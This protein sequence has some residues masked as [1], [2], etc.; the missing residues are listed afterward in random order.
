MADDTTVAELDALVKI[1]GALKIITSEV[2]A[3][4]PKN[5]DLT[6]PSSFVCHDV[7]EL[8]GPDDRGRYVA[9]SAE[10]DWT[11]GY[12]TALLSRL[13]QWRSG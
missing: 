13:R 9:Y 6:L 2:K 1:P 3:K 11:M 5:A 12:P 4:L 7:V 8:A 10:G